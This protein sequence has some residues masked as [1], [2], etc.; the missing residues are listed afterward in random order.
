MEATTFKKYILPSVI[1]GLF[2][3]GGVWYGHYLSDK[4]DKLSSREK[5]ETKS[6]DGTVTKR[7]MEIYK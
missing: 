3:L 5:T 4:N 1:G 7:E 2:L 6:P